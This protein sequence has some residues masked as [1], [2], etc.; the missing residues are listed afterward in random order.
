MTMSATRWVLGA[1]GIAAAAYGG[2]LFVHLGWGHGFGAGVWLIGGV[3][4]HDAVLAPL[5]IALSYLALRSV[6]RD[7]L[8]PW[9]VVLVVVVPVTLVGVPELGRFGAR[10]D[11]P[12]LLDRQYWLGWAVM[13]TLVVVSVVVGEA[14]R[15]RF[16]RV[17]GGEDGQGDGGR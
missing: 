14:A 4:L 16:G 17:R 6:P 5:V 15:R 10:A 13:V 3:I 7:R 12:T 8:A 1:L 9:V 11:N 2:W